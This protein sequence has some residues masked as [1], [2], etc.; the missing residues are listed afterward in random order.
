VSVRTEDSLLHKNG[1]PFPGV[2]KHL[3][4]EEYAIYYSTDPAP[5]VTALLD[6]VRQNGDHLI[7]LRVERPSLEERFLEI[8]QIGVG[9]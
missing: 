8:T 5:T 3:V 9:Q 1:R 2:S 4:N 6:Y 7:D